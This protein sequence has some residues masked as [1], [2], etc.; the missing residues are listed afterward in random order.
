MD[1]TARRNEDGDGLQR[2]RPDVSA[3]TSAANNAVANTDTDYH[4]NALS[5]EELVKE[6]SVDRNDIR[7]TTRLMRFKRYSMKYQ[8]TSWMRSFS[9]NHDYA[10]EK[11]FLAKERKDLRLE[12]DE[13]EI[14]EKETPKDQTVNP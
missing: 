4:E 11:D 6:N 2:S 5:V 7:T 10:W 3:D 14:P 8:S 13:D 12:W 9:T 1:N